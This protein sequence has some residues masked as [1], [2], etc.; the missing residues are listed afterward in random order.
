MAAL[1]P[2]II[3]KHWDNIRAEDLPL[4][5]A[6]P[7]SARYCLMA[8]IV[9]KCKEKIVTHSAILYSALNT[10]RREQVC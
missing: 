3:L 7:N 10:I 8:E 5:M 4:V 1:S 6:D 9:D 2:S